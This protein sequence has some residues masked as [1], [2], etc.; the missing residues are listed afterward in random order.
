M[1]GASRAEHWVQA[2]DGN[3]A[4]L[5]ELALVVVAVVG[6]AVWQLLSLKRDQEALRRRREAEAARDKQDDGP[7]QP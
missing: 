1:C 2:M 4:I 3:R 7:P 5:W 6:F